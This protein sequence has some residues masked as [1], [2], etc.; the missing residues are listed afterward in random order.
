MGAISTTLLINA[1]RDGLMLVSAAARLASVTPAQ[2]KKLID[3]GTLPA[4]T[5]SGRIFVNRSAVE[6]FARPKVV[7]PTRKKARAAQ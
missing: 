2:I 7:E 6:E 1:D 4:Q 3:D 5:R